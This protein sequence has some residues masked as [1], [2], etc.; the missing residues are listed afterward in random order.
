MIK[1]K[2]TPGFGPFNE[3]SFLF[4]SLGADRCSPT[5]T[6]L[7]VESGLR[8]LLSCVQVSP[9]PCHWQHPTESYT[10]RHHSDLEVQVTDKSSG[11]YVCVCEEAGR[12]QPPCRRAEYHLTLKESSNAKSAAHSGNRRFV[13]EYLFIFILGFCLACLLI[14]AIRWNRGKRGIGGHSSST[15]EKGR[16]LLPSSDTPQSPSSA[17]LL[18]EA[19][20]FTEKRNGTLNGHGGHITGLNCTHVYANASGLKL[21]ESTEEVDGRERAGPEGEEEGLTEIGEGL[22]GLEEEL[23]KLQILRGAPLAQCEESSI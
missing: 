17:S 6:E 8:V 18:S 23:A 5:I 10:R 15:S 4:F 11:A 13:A 19:V 16:D 22:S 2:K 21:Q 9:R 12:D 7:P 14:A 3:V 1:H 20:P